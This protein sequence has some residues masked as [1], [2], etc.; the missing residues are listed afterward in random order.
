MIA[1]VGRN[2]VRRLIPSGLARHSVVDECSIDV[3]ALEG[4]ILDLSAGIIS[5]DKRNVWGLSFVGDIAEGDIFHSP[6]WR[7]TVFVVPRNLNLEEAALDDVLNANIFEQHIT[8]KIIV[9]TIDGKTALIIHL[10]LCMAKDVD[11]FIDQPHDAIC[12]NAFLNEGTSTMN[13]DE[14]GMCHISPEDGVLHTDI[15]HTAAETLAS[16]VSCGAIITIA[17][18]HTVIQNMARSKDIQAVAPSRMGDAANIVKR[19][20]AASTHRTSAERDTINE[21]VL[22]AMHMNALVPVGRTADA[23]T[24]DTDILCI[25][26]GKC[27]IDIA[28]WSKIDD[29]G[30]RNTNDVA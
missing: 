14:D 2:K 1:N 10:C 17:T 21:N 9:S 7:S 12:L 11:V 16:G 30:G 22:A 28:A 26:N 15:V 5:V 27:T 23:T 8:N 3:Q 20:T 4:D 18:E 13:A 29:S 24:N 6:S 25:L 19:N